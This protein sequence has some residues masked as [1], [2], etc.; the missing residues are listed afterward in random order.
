[1]RPSLPLGRFAKKT[2]FP[3]STICEGERGGAFVIGLL[4][5]AA[6]YIPDRERNA[7]FKTFS[8]EKLNKVCIDCGAP[9][10]QWATAFF[11]KCAHHV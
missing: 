9:N 3:R 2:R 1:M 5:M 11:G 4:D 10:P 6:R 8:K 7:F